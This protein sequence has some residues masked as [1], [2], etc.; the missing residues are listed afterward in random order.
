MPSSSELVS[1]LLP[2]YNSMEYIA[3]TLNSV[4]EQTHPALE[5]IVVD[6]GSTDQT[7]KIVTEIADPRVKLFCQT[8]KGAGAA[9]NHAFLNSSGRY[10]VFLDSDDLI[11]PS[12]I[13]ALLASISGSDTDIAFGQWDRFFLTPEEASFPSRATNQ[14]LEATD[15]ILLD[16]DQVRMTQCGMFLIPRRII[17]ENGGWN[18]GLSAG[19]NDDFEFFARIL[20]KSQSLRYSPDAK[21]FYRSGIQNSLSG[22]KARPAIEAKLRSLE[23]GTSHLLNKRSCS[24]AR[25]VC[26][27]IL[28]RFIFEQYPRD[29]DLLARARERINQLGGSKMEPVGTPGFERL[30]PFLGWR[31]ARRT[32]VLA[33]ALK[34]NSAS[35]A[36]RRAS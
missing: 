17:E 5:I 8:N 6:D 28:Q 7:Q 36:S 21:L 26:A 15:W 25:R 30:K 22:R 24:K 32:E 34:L 18:P 33:Q 12:H 9:R 1:I 10:V 27:D 23:L 19:P 29:S 3:P 35:R 16:W 20:S 11:V 14:T 13:E 2:T 4:L 31:L